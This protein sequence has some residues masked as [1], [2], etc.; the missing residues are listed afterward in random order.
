VQGVYQPLYTPLNG[1]CG[2]VPDA[3]NVLIEGDLQI[4]NLSTVEV[5][6]QTQIKGCY[7]SMNQQVIDRRNNVVQRRIVGDLLDVMSATHVAGRV[8]LTR[9]DAAGMAIC[10]GEYQADLVKNTTT[11]GG[12]VTGSGG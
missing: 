11:H 7:V 2:P 1:T 8:T 12:A 6:T 10:A 5:H 9:Y 3:N 4:Q